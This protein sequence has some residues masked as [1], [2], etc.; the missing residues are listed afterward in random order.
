MADKENDANKP[1]VKKGKDELTSPIDEMD[2]MLEGFFGRSWPRSWM[3]P[4]HWEFPSW[5]ETSLPFAGRLPRIDIIDNDETIVVKAEIPGVSKEDL[6]ITTTA[7][8]VTIHGHTSHESKQEAGDYFR[9]EMSRGEFSRTVAL[10]CEVDSDNATANLDN[11][12]LELKLPK[13]AKAK[14]RTIEIT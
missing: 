6:E 10:P 8:S 2:R 9:A 12:I 3:H 7:T 14:R 1:I 13:I 11:G 5:S 4:F